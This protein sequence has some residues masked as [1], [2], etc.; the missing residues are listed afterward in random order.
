M[1][2]EYMVCHI[3]LFKLNVGKMN[4][5]NASLRL[6]SSILYLYLFSQTNAFITA[7]R[8]GS[9]SKY[10]VLYVGGKH[11]RPM[12][13]D[14]LCDWAIYV[15]PTPVRYERRRVLGYAVLV[16]VRLNCF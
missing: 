13:I 11:M 9:N 16:A 2:E 8:T 1:G 4:K 10:F 15:K 6:A 12:S 7:H 14:F 5:K 3:T